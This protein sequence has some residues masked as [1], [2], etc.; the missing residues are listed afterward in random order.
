M[1]LIDRRLAF[2]WTAGDRDAAATMTRDDGLRTT[3][4]FLDTPAGRLFTVR[5]DGNGPARGGVVICPPIY[6]EAARNQRRE[7]V[8]GWELSSVGFTAVRFQYLGSG[9]SD[10]EPERMTFA[11][12][13]DDTTTVARDLQATCGGLPIAFVGTR[14]GALVA[15][16]AA[17]A[18]PGTPLVLWEPPIDMAR[19][20]NEILRARMI[21]LLKSGQR[22]AS[23]KEVMETF[24]R[25]GVL[26]VVGSPLAYSLYES[27]R[28]LDVEDLIVAAGPRPVSIV[29]MSVK[30]ELRPALKELV[31]RC[32]RPGVDLAA[33]SVSYDEAWWF[34]ASGYRVLEVE[35]G[36]LDVVPITTQFLETVA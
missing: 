36:G 21:G 28:Q 14:L 20:Y 10:G 4:A 18:F 12:M 9:H 24:A 19:Y 11:Q 25:V 34:G 5:H 16:S 8:L 2:G 26:D 17:A 7:V 30:P 22:S 15:A 31:E 27:T 13:V 3:A 23:T 1:E 29:Q 33:T 35:S 32:R 6:A